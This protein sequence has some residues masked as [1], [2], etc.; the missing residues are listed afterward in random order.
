MKIL[1]T[2][3]ARYGRQLDPRDERDYKVEVLG[4]EELKLSAFGTVVVFLMMLAEKKRYVYITISYMIQS[5]G[6][7]IGRGLL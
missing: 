2:A 1:L 7:Y 4:D 3:M 5:Y 6:N